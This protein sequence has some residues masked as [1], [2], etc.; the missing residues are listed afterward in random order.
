MNDM[1]TSSKLTLILCA[2]SA[3]ILSACG[4]GSSTTSTSSTTTSVTAF[5]TGV[6]VGSPTELSS[7][8]S[9]VASLN[10]PPSQRFETWA[11]ATWDAVKQGNWSDLKQLAW[12]GLPLMTA[13]ASTDKVP[14]A[15]VTASEIEAIATGS[16]TLAQIG[17]TLN[18]L[19]ATQSPNAGCFG[20]KLY[21]Q[22]HDNGSDTTPAGSDPYP[23][24]PSGD[25]G[26]WTAMDAET[27]QPCAAAQMNARLGK[28]KKQTRQGMLLMASMRRAIAASASLS[29][30]VAG[31]QTDLT[32]AISTIVSA[33]SAS[34]TINA[35]TLD[36]NGAGTIYT[37]RLVLSRGTGA[38]AES[39]EIVIRHAPG[40]SLTQFS[41]VMS[42]VV[43]Q[44]SSD[45]AF[46]C[47]DET[48]SISSTSYYKVAS[49]STLRYDRNGTSLKFGSR[50]GQYCGAPLNASADHLGNLATLDSNNE[51]DPSA[52]LSGNTRSSV[53]GWR[54][55]FS[56]FAGDLDKDT[57]AGDF[58]YVWQAGTGDSN[59]R[60]FQ[61]HS[62]YNSGTETRTAKAFFG[63]TAAITGTPTSLQGMICNWAGPG[64]SH[65]P[66]SKFQ[67]QLMTLT[68][69]A[70][71]WAMDNADSHIAYAPTTSCTID[72]SGTMVFDVD[73]SDT[74]DSGEGRSGTLDLD[75]P[76]GSNTV[77]QEINARGYTP[78]TLF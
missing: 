56:R 57:Q 17:L 69:S 24:L 76:S 50:F 48:T 64:N 40:A 36:L 42:I 39:A 53:K 41:G 45:P 46:G 66:A 9:V 67:S 35:A 49:I 43:S 58:L 23:S 21:Y 22:H 18:D 10:L 65:T 27:G 4:G 20:P 3:A 31:G 16:R 32:S 12:Q 75:V 77:Q 29:M 68:S 7:T 15:K 13:Q 44:L 37:Y 70:T 55:N 34:T 28:V 19:F 2:T 54:G 8:S 59:G 1:K 71:A 25:L 73:L 52:T 14:E 11:L 61:V 33:L 74:I 72:N 60:G 47:T 63:Y 51:L 62:A 5:P 30:P 6:A 38:S 26:L 78:P